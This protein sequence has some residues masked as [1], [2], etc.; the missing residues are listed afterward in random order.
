M[1]FER[2]VV[3]KSKLCVYLFYL[4]QTKRGSFLNRNKNDLA[5]MAS[6]L[7]P[8]ANPQGPRNN[9]SFVFQSADSTMNEDSRSSSEP[10]KVSKTG[11]LQPQ[12]KDVSLL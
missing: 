1:T 5:K 9:K 6:M 3:S 12:N 10:P 11:H 4:V 7:K 8:V 2:K